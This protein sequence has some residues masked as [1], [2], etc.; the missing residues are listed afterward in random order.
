M[1]IQVYMHIDIFD[2][3]RRY[4]LKILKIIGAAHATE[5]PLIAENNKLV[6]D[7]G[8][9]IYPKG[10]SLIHQRTSL[11]ST[12]KNRC[13]ENH[14]MAFW[15][16]YTKSSN[17]FMILDK[18]KNLKIENNIKSFDKLLDELS[19]DN[20]VNALEKCVILYQM[21]SLIG[22]DIYTNLESKFSHSCNK[23]S[24]KDFLKKNASYVSY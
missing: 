11:F 24:S 19:I 4:Q 12:C 6:G 23:E 17:K 1:V 18:K 7:Y 8:F 16:K 21:G 3:H 22:N 20:R 15:D 2:D 13:L 9:L 5:I 10:L 14:L